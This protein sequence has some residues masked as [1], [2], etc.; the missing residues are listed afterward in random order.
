MNAVATTTP[1]LITDS[2]KTKELIL[3]SKKVTSISDD[4]EDT[5]PK[6][7]PTM[8]AMQRLEDYLQEQI[9]NYYGAGI[10]VV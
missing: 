3:D 10:Y 9:D 7:I 1:E 4:F 2:V 5:D 6:T 8:F